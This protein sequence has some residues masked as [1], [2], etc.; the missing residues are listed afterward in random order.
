[1][2]TRIGRHFRDG[3]TIASE[4]T[5]A[6]QLD[7][8]E[9]RGLIPCCGLVWQV[10]KERDNASTRDC[11]P[12]GKA[13]NDLAEPRSV[14]KMARNQRARRIF[15]QFRHGVTAYILIENGKRVSQFQHV[16]NLGIGVDACAMIM[17]PDGIERIVR[18]ARREAVGGHEPVSRPVCADLIVIEVVAIPDQ[19][20][21][22]GIG[23][24][25]AGKAVHDLA[26]K[27]RVSGTR[28]V[29]E[30]LPDQRPC[31]V[32]CQAPIHPRVPNSAE[33]TRTWVAPISMAISKSPLMPIETLGK[34][35]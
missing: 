2:P 10:H 17:R 12:I 23:I 30:L 35:A 14:R 26:D 1:M 27:Q 22:L 5:H 21:E 25:E 29:S 28:T 18:K 8:T 9:T 24:D 4:C 3:A 34:P 31:F 6:N 20:E 16:G 11:V 15:C 19:H 7:V 32:K 13:I 33:P